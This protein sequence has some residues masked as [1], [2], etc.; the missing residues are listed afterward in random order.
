M[1]PVPIAADYNLIR[2]RRQAVIDD[3]NR[4]ANLRRRFHDYSVDDQVLLILPKTSKLREKTSGP[5]RITQVH[6][7]GTV[8]IERLPNVYERVNVRRLKPFFPRI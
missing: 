6:I 8:T 2:E 1:L 4:R 3:N 7:N 5:F